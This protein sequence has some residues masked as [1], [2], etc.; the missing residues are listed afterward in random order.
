[1]LGFLRQKDLEIMPR[2][3]TCATNTPTHTLSW[4]IKKKPKTNKI[5]KQKSC[6]DN[7]IKYRF[8]VRQFWQ[9]S[10]CLVKPI[11]LSFHVFLDFLLSSL[12]LVPFLEFPSW[13]SLF[14]PF[15]FPVFYRF[16][17]RMM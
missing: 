6:Q 12:F 16:V 4:P 17:G 7:P 1:M 10:P 14:F 13:S 9:F 5:G 2:D 15:L 8:G 11:N 3:R